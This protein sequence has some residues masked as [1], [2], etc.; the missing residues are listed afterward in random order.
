MTWIGLADH[1]A[2]Y[3]TYRPPRATT[4]TRLPIWS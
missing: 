3:K 2:A 1:T 4:A